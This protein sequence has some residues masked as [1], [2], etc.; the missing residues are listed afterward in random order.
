MEVV[1]GALPE[2][3]HNHTVTVHAYIQ[4]QVWYLICLRYCSLLFGS[5]VQ[6][7]FSIK[8]LAY[9]H[10]PHNFTPFENEGLWATTR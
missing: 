6:Q 5:S 9:Q 3:I 1:E 10:G 4:P 8:R 7:Y 2:A